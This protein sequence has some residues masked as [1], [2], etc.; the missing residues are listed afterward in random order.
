[1]TNAAMTY[2]DRRTDELRS[3]TR[4]SYGSYLE[5]A[6]FY[7]KILTG[8]IF[9]DAQKAR[10]DTART[11]LQTS[12]R[13]NGTASGTTPGYTFNPIE[14]TRIAPGAPLVAAIAGHT[15]EGGAGLNRLTRSESDRGRSD[16]SRT[17]GMTE[18]VLYGYVSDSSSLFGPDKLTA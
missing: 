5:W 18:N 14:L 9:L 8:R 2:V 12:Y 7:D 4:E 15:I 16:G 10:E 13:A 17:Y 6:H 1:R 3:R 11:S